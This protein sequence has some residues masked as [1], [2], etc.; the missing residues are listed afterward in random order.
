M[1]SLRAR[2]P[3][4]ALLTVAI[5]FTV[6]VEG[7]QTSSH[8]VEDADILVVGQVGSSDTGSTAGGCPDAQNPPINGT[9]F[10]RSGVLVDNPKVSDIRPVHSNTLTVCA[11]VVKPF[12]FRKELDDQAG[13]PGAEF[14]GHSEVADSDNDFEEFSSADE[15]MRQYQG[16]SVDII[17]AVW[18]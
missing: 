15:F 6:G 1:N 18:K 9:I 11:T 5:I 13:G 16:Y 3:L 10:S 8:A 14:R 12:V 17:V 4:A 2:K 7:Q